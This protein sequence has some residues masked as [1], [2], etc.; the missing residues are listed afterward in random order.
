MKLKRFEFLK[1]VE[2]TRN[3]VEFEDSYDRVSDR[4]IE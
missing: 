3:E 4:A 1:I 2:I